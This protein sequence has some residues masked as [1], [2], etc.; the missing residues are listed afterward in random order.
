MWY[1]VSGGGEGR[2]G[3]E[4]EAEEEKEAEA[5]AARSICG[6]HILAVVSDKPFLPLWASDTLEDWEARGGT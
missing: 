4:E 3:V 5:E 1:L 6:M 2:K